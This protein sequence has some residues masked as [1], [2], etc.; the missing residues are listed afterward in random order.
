MLHGMQ[1]TGNGEQWTR[2][3]FNK[4]MVS[5]CLIGG[6]CQT[7]KFCAVSALVSSRA[8]MYVQDALLDEEGANEFGGGANAVSLKVPAAQARQEE[9]VLNAQEAHEACCCLISFSLTT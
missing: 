1:D 5:P 9:R 6:T 7:T 8:L 2:F 4:V 3:M